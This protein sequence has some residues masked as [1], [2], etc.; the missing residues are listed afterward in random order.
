VYYAEIPTRLLGRLPKRGDEV[1]E[2][3]RFPEVRRDLSM[4]IPEGVTYQAIESLAFATEKKLLKNVSLFDVYKGDR[5]GGAQ[6]YAL[7]FT[8]LDAQKTLDE[9]TIDKAMNRLVRAFEEK[10]GAKLRG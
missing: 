1:A 2:A 4:I 7:R 10:L 9:K 8:L 5:L 6:S 3:P